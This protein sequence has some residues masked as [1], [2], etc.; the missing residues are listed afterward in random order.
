MQNKKIY[1]LCSSSK[2]TE[3]KLKGM[4]QTDNGRG[5]VRIKCPLENLQER[6]HSRDLDLDG[7]KYI[8]NKQDVTIWAVFMPLRSGTSGNLL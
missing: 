6:G 2:I 3:Y 1:N 8:L 4:R 5:D 7:I